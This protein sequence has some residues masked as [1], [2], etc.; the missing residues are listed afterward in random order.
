MSDYRAQ[1]MG[2]APRDRNILLWDRYDTAWTIGCWIAE[3]GQWLADDAEPLDPIAWCDL[4]PPLPSIE[5]D[6]PELG[7]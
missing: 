6:L 1:P 4:P 2:T 3:W 5:L 7:P